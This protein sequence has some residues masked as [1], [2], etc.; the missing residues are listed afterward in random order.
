MRNRKNSQTLIRQGRLARL[1]DAN[2][3]QTLQVE[4]MADEVFEDVERVQNYGFSSNPSKGGVYGFKVGGKSNQLVVVVINDDTDRVRLENADDVAVYHREGHKIVLTQDGVIRISCKK[5]IGD[6]EESAD[7]NT[8]E[9]TVTASGSVTVDTPTTTITGDTTIEGAL[10]VNG[11]TAL[12]GG[13]T[14][15]G[16]LHITGKSTADEDH[17]SNGVSGAYH[18]HKDSIGGTTTEPNK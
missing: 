16:D 7:I 9:A 15:T 12:G 8:I 18:D 6:A 11:A 5:I 13:G 2:N 17:V 14:V 3:T 4:L 1:D 10:T